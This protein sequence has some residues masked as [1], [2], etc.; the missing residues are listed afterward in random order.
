[1]SRIAKTQTAVT[2]VRQDG[3]IVI[4]IN[5]PISFSL[6]FTIA[7]LKFLAVFLRLLFK[8]SGE[9]VLTLQQTA[10]VLGYKDRR[11]VDNYC[12]EF[13]R[14]GCDL[15]ALL[16]RK[17]QLLQYVALIESFVLQNLLLPLNVMHQ[18][19]TAQHRVKM[20]Y[21]TFCKYVGQLDASSV[22]RQAQKLLWNKMSGGDTINLLRILA[23]QHNVPVICDQLLEYAKAFGPKQKQ[24]NTASF[25]LNM[26]RRNLCLLVHYL[27]GKGMNQ[28]TI[29]MLLNTS[30]ATVS[31][32][33]H[34]IGDLQSIILNSIAKWSGKISID[35][36]FIRIRGV[37]FY[38]I[39][40][41]DFVTGIPLYL[42]LFKNTRK[43]S[44]EACF[45][46]FHL[47]YKKAPTLIVSDG[48]QSLAA[49][50]KAAFPNVPHQLC[51]FHKI[52][53]LFK[54]ISNSKIAWEEKIKLKAKVVK[55]F[56]RD[57]VSGRKK[58]LRELRSLVPK[59]AAEYIDCNVLKHWKQ[60]C[61]GLTSNVS[62]RFNRKIEKVMSG[63]Y[64]LKSEQTALNLA[65]SLWVTVLIDKGKPFLHEQSLI[66]SLNIS[67]MC[68]ENVDWTH[69]DHLFSKRT[70]KAA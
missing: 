31:N 54:K 16:S 45:R 13:I 67:R 39:T 23:D 63:R 60:L 48:S 32:L 10:D 68:Q 46:A 3:K 43:E 11:D 41:V 55:V 7:N 6:P 18:K 69:L 56:R 12:R 29:A 44:Y 22:V 24:A 61:K 30:R 59:P 49:G 62:E 9:K 57:S 53:N 27:M 21:P 28:S 8:L 4:Q 33:W 5:C 58:G 47:I 50:R 51:K 14:K 65:L 38:I 70:G 36:K 15:A 52:R 26:Q 64:G 34:E 20:S 35:E 1:M 19:F 25:P 40:I 17:V 42:N 37:P 2:V 66:A